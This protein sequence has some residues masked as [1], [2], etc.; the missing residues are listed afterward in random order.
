M[1]GLLNPKKFFSPTIVKDSN[2]FYEKHIDNINHKDIEYM[3]P[4]MDKVFDKNYKRNVMDMPI[5][6][7]MGGKTGTAQVRRI[8]KKDRKNNAHKLWKWKS[9]DHSI[10]TGYSPV[11]NP[12]FVATVIVEHGGWGSKV[13]A[14]LGR[15]ILIKA[16]EI[17]GDKS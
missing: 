10:F 11:K 16:H 7:S 9:R 17:I 12:R 2:N 5:D 1:V 13:A 6:F 15:D 4:L 8:K 14:P 3:K